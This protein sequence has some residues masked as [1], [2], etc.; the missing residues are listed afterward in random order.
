VTC[1]IHQNDIGTTIKVQISDCNDT[2]ID[3]SAADV[4][5]IVFKK[6]SGASLTKTANFT[7][8]GVDGL[9]EYVVAAGDFDEVGTYKIEAVV[10]VGSYI[11][12][13]NF[14][15]FRVYRNLI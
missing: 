15:S 2:A 13:S 6:P 9:I 12:H 10:T 4:K 5:Q 3:I 7:T 14:E 11:W 1:G 8:T